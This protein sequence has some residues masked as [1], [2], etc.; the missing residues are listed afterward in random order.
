MKLDHEMVDL[1]TELIERKTG[2]FR[3][4]AFEDHYETELRKL[5]ARKAKGERIVTEPEPETPRGN[6]INLMDALRDSLKRAAQRCPKP[7]R[8]PS[9]AP[10]KSASKARQGEV[11]AKAGKKPRKTGQSHSAALARL[12]RQARLFENRGTRAP[13]RRAPPRQARL[14]GAEARRTA[15][16]LRSPA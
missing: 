11:M 8:K 13:P 4:E 9:A 10:R 6:V 7:R 2:R 12:F 5:I 15:P 1:A 16:S 3:P 14:R